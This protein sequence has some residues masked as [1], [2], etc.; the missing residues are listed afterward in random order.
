VDRFNQLK[1]Q[2]ALR[3]ETLASQVARSVPGP[4]LQGDIEILVD[5]LDALDGALKDVQHIG[6]E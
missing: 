4:S 1:A 5:V 3:I 2:I 6:E